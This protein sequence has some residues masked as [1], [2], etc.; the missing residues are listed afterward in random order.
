[1][2]AER[3]DR[4]I[5]WLWQ[6]EGQPDFVTHVCPSEWDAMWE[7]SGYKITPVGP[8]TFMPYRA[9]LIDPFKKTVEGYQFGF[10]KPGH[11]Y[12]QEAIE[13]L[14]GE[15]GTFTAIMVD[16][17]NVMYLDDNGIAAQTPQFLFNPYPQWLHGKALILG[18]D[19][20]GD[21]ADTTCSLEGI[22]NRVQFR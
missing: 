11:E 21:S 17:E 20:E 18:Y 22:R 12:I 13:P 2:A 3:K 10:T 19:N 9:I 8:K 14:Y 4:P 15:N 16:D 5:G 1:M 7:A 6:K